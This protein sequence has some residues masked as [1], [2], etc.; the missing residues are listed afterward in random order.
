[1]WRPDDWNPIEHYIKIARSG[2]DTDLFEAGA[3]AMLKV[4][5]EKPSTR[6]TPFGWLVFI[7]NPDVP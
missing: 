6:T 7:P 4:L 2:E 5:I 3:D 1:M